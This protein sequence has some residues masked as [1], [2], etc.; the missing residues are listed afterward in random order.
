MHSFIIFICITHLL[1][2]VR[3][4]F[5][6]L[7]SQEFSLHSMLLC[8]EYFTIAFV[9]FSIFLIWTFSLFLYF[10]L[11]SGLDRV[12]CTMTCIAI[13]CLHPAPRKRTCWSVDSIVSLLQ[14]QA[15]RHCRLKCVTCGDGLFLCFTLIRM[16]ILL[17]N[18]F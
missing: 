17:L 12:L 8:Y 5:I 4:P 3:W 14:P 18:V 6:Q 1:S 7:P 16:N 11:M 13:K 15:W 10:T 2:S 9:L